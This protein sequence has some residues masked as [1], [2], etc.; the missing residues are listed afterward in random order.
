MAPNLPEL[1]ELELKVMQIVW[2]HAPVTAELVR[3]RLGRRLK[4]S[5][6]RTVLRRLEEKG[7]IDHSIQGRTY[8]F[9]PLHD[10]QRVAANAVHRIANW[11]CNGAID[12]VVL[13]VVDAKMLSKGQL[14]KLSAK[15]EAAK[16]ARK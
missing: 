16:Q 10:R 6:V 4:E 3:E 15:I 8:L 5:T 14:E 2:A 11:F 13:G 7:F 1:G 9:R 12:Q